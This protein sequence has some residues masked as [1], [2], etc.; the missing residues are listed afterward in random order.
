MEKSENKNVPAI[1]AEVFNTENSTDLILYSLQKEDGSIDKDKLREFIRETVKLRKSS[2]EVYSNITKGL[3][4]NWNY[5][6]ETV[7]SVVNNLQKD[8]VDKSEICEDI[9]H[10]VQDEGTKQLILE[11]FGKI[12]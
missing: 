3:L 1:D 5:P 8:K 2:S 9:L 6:A 11:Y 10:L 12:Y 7:L 4:S